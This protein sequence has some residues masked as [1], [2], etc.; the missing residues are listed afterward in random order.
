MT[1][2]QKRQYNAEYYRNNPHLKERAKERKRI[3]REK[4]ARKQMEE[5]QKNGFGFE[6]ESEEIS[7]I[8][9]EIAQKGT[10]QMANTKD[11]DS[12]NEGI[13]SSDLPL[14]K[15]EAETKSAVSEKKFDKDEEFLEAEII[16]KP[17]PDE[18]EMDQTETERP[19]HL[20]LV[21]KIP[22][23]FAEKVN[24]KI[25]NL[26][27]TQLEFHDELEEKLGSKIEEN[28]AKIGEKI[29]Q[30]HEE[31]KRVSELNLAKV[32]EK[33]QTALEKVSDN[34]P[35]VLK[36][37]EVSNKVSESRFGWDAVSEWFQIILYVSVLAV[38][39]F[40]VVSE[41]S[42]RLQEAGHSYPLLMA[43]VLDVAIIGLA[44][45]RQELSFRFSSPVDFLNSVFSILKFLGFKLALVG[46]VGFSFWVSM[47]SEKVSGTEK[48]A[49]VS[50]TEASKDIDKQIEI[51]LAAL[52][53]FQKKGESGNI[54][55]TQKELRE[56]RE[57]RA[58]SV[59]SGD[60]QNLKSVYEDE[61]NMK[62]ASKGVPLMINILF[63][64]LLGLCW[65]KRKKPL[66]Y[67]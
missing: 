45:F 35:K 11:T 43:L 32:S 57:L 2:E 4:E 60:V 49:A 50:K 48:I 46:L 55:K 16:E 41:N 14:K 27:L 7:F 33:F 22:E 8:R 3:R 44:S 54:A 15:T 25:E 20:R 37:E 23:E 19:N 1:P 30:T 53:D 47:V 26:K 29:A 36:P 51:T 52:S 10:R 9:K 39:G 56:L 5:I 59:R 38:S 34:Q 21:E 66:N 62:I 17:E 40:I 63:G 12:T 6:F 67:A 58:S 64:H 31:F 13:F 18:E 61:K 65:I 24:E 28:H 42:F